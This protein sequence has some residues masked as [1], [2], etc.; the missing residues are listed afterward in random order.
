MAPRSSNHPESVPSFEYNPHFRGELQLEDR[1][2][3]PRLQADLLREFGGQALLVREIIER[4]H[5]GKNYIKKNYKRALK[6]LEAVSR[7]TIEPPA[8][9]RRAGTLNEKTCVVTFPEGGVENGDQVL[10]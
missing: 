9:Q 2:W 7:V 6:D 4:H 8:G 3:I 5:V 1:S 10:N